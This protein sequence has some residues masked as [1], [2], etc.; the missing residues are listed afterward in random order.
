MAKQTDHRDSVN[1]AESGDIREP[2][3]YLKL[4]TLKFCT[5]MKP[6]KKI[7]S[8]TKFQPETLGLFS[9]VGNSEHLP[10]F[11]IPAT[12]ILASLQEGQ[13]Y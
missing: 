12:Q 10:K 8:H 5:G 3:S 4:Q 9:R 7:G 1:A 2:R 6:Y 11:P 13:L